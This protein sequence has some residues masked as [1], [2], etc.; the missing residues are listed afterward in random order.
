LSRGPRRPPPR[1]AART[2]ANYTE[3]RMSDA[4][5]QQNQQELIGL[6]NLPETAQGEAKQVAEGIDITDSQ[7]VMQYGVGAQ[8]KISN[9][10]DQILTEIRNKD[11]GYVGEILGG[12]MTTI[13][14]VDVESLSDEKGLLDKMFGGLKRRISKFMQRYETLATQIDKIVGDLESAKMNL[15][16]DIT[17]L[18]NLYEKNMEYLQD[19]DVHIAAGKMKLEEYRRRV[20]P[21]MQTKAEESNDPLDAQRLQDVNQLLNRFEK[22]L[23]D[24][25]LSR[26][27]AIQ[28]SPQIRL[29]Q[30][31]NQTLVEKIQSS[32]LN[33]IPLWKNQIVIAVS[34]FRQQKALELQREVSNTTNDLLKRNAEML[35]SGS[36][37]V[38]KESERGIVEIETLKKVNEDLIST[39]DET[40]QIQ[41]EGRRKRAEAETEL[42]KMEGELK[43]R[44]RRVHG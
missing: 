30:N 40:L 14:D 32:V 36:T 18:D 44:L 37:G 31:N 3:E 9:F 38:A 43:E 5:Q 19:L 29:I 34:L 1:P 42:Q 16:K 24:M 8:T 21:E 23:Y 11:S 4:M 35:K 41:E 10:A 28:T 7:A 39:I 27:V 2:R 17:L 6:D 33:T 25:Q 12:L 20:I 26:M 22:K 15:L 13:K